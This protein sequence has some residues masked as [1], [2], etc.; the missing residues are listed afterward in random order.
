[1]TEPYENNWDYLS[2]E[3][4][5]LN[6]LIRREVSSWHEPAAQEQQDIFRGV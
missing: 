2:A 4:S 5:R 1:M 3:L 6:L